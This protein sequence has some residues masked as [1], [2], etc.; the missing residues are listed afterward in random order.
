V[1]TITKVFGAVIGGL[2]LALQVPAVQ[3][4]LGSFLGAHPNVSAVFAGLLGIAALFHSPA[5]AAPAAPAPTA[6]K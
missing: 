3:S 5:P 1:K 4:G 2:T 6:S